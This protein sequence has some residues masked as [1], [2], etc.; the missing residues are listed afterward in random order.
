LAKGEKGECIVKNSLNDMKQTFGANIHTLL[1]DSFFMHDKGLMGKFAEGKINDVILWLND[2]SNKNI[3]KLAKEQNGT[4]TQ[5]EKELKLVQW[6]I[7]QI[8]EPIIRNQLQ[9]MLDSRRLEKVE[10]HDEQ[11][12]KLE[13]SMRFLQKQIE[14]LKNKK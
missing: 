7:K 12:K 2:G 1:T 6:L 14:K 9:K 13:S 5:A 11:I 4:E 8:G 10:T 3:T